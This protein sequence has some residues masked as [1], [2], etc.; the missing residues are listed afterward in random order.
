MLVS[1]QS[2]SVQ[3]SNNNINQPGIK[4]RSLVLS[5]PNC[6]AISK[7]VAKIALVNYTTDDMHNLCNTN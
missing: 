4:E 6:H 5:E 2:L 1:L 7:I 3:A